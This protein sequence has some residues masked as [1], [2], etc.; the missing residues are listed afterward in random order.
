MR[1]E[2]IPR[3]GEV[4]D[5][6]QR[7][8][9]RRRGNRRGDLVAILPQQHLGEGTEAFAGLAAGRG[10][11]LP[12]GSFRTARGL[13][14][15]A[16]VAFGLTAL[17]LLAA[18]IRIVVVGRRGRRFGLAEEQVKT[19]AERALFF[20]G[21]RQRHQKGV[22][23]DLP[24]GESHLGDRA[25]RIDAFG[26]RDPDPGSPRRPKE[27]MQVL[28]HQWRSAEFG[29]P[30]PSGERSLIAAM[31]AIVRR[32]SGEGALLQRETV[33][34]HPGRFAIRPLPRER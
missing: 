14:T 20:L 7:R 3:S 12:F 21:F 15:A 23:Q 16:A 34:P 5:V 17:A 22:A 9:V 29:S 27:A 13:A 32:K 10:R 19:V 2:K 26:G 24:V 31:T 18:F 30:L 1:P 28:A 11:C 25:H 6:G 8:R 4:A 33:T